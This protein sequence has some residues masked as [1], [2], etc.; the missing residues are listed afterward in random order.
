[1]GLE[2]SK[3]YPCHFFHVISAKRYEDI[4]YHHGGI[5]VISFLAIR[6]VLTILWDFEILT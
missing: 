6:Q 4:V 5:P 2:I 1:M 3:H